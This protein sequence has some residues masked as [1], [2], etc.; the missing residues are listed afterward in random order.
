VS[1]SPIPA[2]LAANCRNSP[3]GTAWL[4]RVPGI[5]N[6]L[7]E[8]WALS[9]DNPFDCPD[10]SC[11][12]VA[13]AQRANGVAAVL[14]VGM[15]H[16]EA[17][18]EIAGLHFWNGDPVVHLLEA[19]DELNAMLLERCRPGTSLRSLPEP[20]QD[21]IVAQLLN[22]LWRHPTPGHPFRPL[23]ALI[24]YWRAE[25][26]ADAGNWSDPELVRDGLAVFDNLLRTPGTE[27]LLATD[28]HA[29]NILQAER[30]PWLVI[31]P[32]PFVGEPAYDLTQHL[33][34]CQ[35][36]LQANPIALINRLAD[37]AQLNRE[38]VR[39]WAFARAAADPR[40]DWNNPLARIARSIR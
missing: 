32:K 29:G 17:E 13:P 19:D 6:N 36:R 21:V 3:E 31:D 40:G 30:V 14:K 12:W 28:L 39:L 10:V 25:T 18:H 26:L 2:R 8:R 11:A 5:V 7:R 24:D 34:N 4:A 1:H 23:S 22:R 9:L 27:V 20:E 16:M 37:L 33:F 15:P 35:E 38:R